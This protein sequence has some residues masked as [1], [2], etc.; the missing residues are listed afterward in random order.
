[1]DEIGDSVTSKEEQLISYMK[2][3]LLVSRIDF[4]DKSTFFET[5]VFELY[6]DLFPPEERDAPNDIMDWVL[7]T[8]IGKRKSVKLNSEI[9]FDYCLDS[10]Y[11]MLTLAKKKLLDLPF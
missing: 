8:D 2:P 4:W 3:Q 10:R 9:Q 7:E 11:C 1:M 6:E 5:D